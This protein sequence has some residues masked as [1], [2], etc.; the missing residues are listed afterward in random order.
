MKHL[1]CYFLSNYCSMVSMHKMYTFNRMR[2]IGWILE[3]R[4]IFLHYSKCK[5]HLISTNLSS[6][7]MWINALGN[8]FVSYNMQMS[9]LLDDI[10]KHERSVYSPHVIYRGYLVSYDW[11]IKVSIGIN[12]VCAYY[13]RISTSEANGQKILQN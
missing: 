13:H 7:Y 10:Y 2:D 11:I 8:I 6:W 5:L 9:S 4:Y 3:M 12:Y 1:H